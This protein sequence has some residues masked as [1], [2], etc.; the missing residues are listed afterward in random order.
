MIETEVKQFKQMTI[1]LK[2]QTEATTKKKWKTVRGDI[3][4]EANKSM[5]STPWSKQGLIN[6]RMWI[7]N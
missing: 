5:S 7:F 4:G 2:K 3:L 6:V 1:H